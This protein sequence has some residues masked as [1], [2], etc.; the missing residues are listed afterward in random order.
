MDLCRANLTRDTPGIEELKY[1]LNVIQEIHDVSM[2]MEL[3]FASVAEKFRV[4]MK[5][6]VL[7]LNVRSDPLCSSVRLCLILPENA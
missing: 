2:N 1:V 3:E 6:S 5:Y 4:L 7:Q